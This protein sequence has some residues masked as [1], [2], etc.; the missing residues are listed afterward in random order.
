MILK[1]PL[2]TALAEKTW[3][4]KVSE[5]RVEGRESAL[6]W[7]PAYL[8]WSLWKALPKLMSGLQG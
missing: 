2:G 6:H 1:R 8:W 3:A 5:G 4:Y 7:A